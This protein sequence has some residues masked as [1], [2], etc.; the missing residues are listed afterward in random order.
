MNPYNGFIKPYT[1][2]AIPVKIVEHVPE[3]VSI[4]LEVDWCKVTPEIK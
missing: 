4:K 1:N 2:M 3:N